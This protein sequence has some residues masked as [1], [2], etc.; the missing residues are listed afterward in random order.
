MLHKREVTKKRLPGIDWRNILS[1]KVKTQ[2]SSRLPS[3]QSHPQPSAFCAP[4]HWAHNGQGISK[5]KFSL[6]SHGVRW[7][8]ISA[9]IFPYSPKQFYK[10]FSFLKYFGKYPH[11]LEFLHNNSKFGQVLEKEKSRW[12]WGN[13]PGVL[14]SES[15]LLCSVLFMYLLSHLFIPKLC[16]ES[17]TA[18]LLPAFYR[19]GNSR[20]LRTLREE[21]D[22]KLFGHRTETIEELRFSQYSLFM[23]CIEYLCCQEL[24]GHWDCNSEQNS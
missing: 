6:Y 20:M 23:I 9:Y 10:V 22:F 13:I 1:G 4:F 24:S 2:A 15:S 5:S 19:W 18:V 21:S 17:T 16:E 7:S 3:S 12:V 14:L 11:F 8:R